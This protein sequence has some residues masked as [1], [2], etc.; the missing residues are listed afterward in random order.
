MPDDTTQPPTDSTS[1]PQ[2]EPE[3][4]TP[5]SID[6]AQA[7]PETASLGT[8]PEPTPPSETQA[9][10]VPPEAVEAP[11]EAV[12]IAPVNNDI[13]TSESPVAESPMP[14][15]PLPVSAPAPSSNSTQINRGNLPKARAKIQETKQQKLDKIMVR[16]TEKSKISNDEVEKLLRVSDA[17]ATRYLSALEKEGKIKQAGRTGKSVFYEK[18]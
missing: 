4:T 13:S 2:A 3:V 15:N 1:S 18:I 8:T 12:D 17:T 16:L 10:E 14:E 9:P 7:S 6:S 5:T 11:R